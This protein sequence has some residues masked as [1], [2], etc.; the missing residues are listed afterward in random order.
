[1]AQR[2]VEPLLSDLVGISTSV[3][4]TLVLTPSMPL[5]TLGFRSLV[6][7]AP[8]HPAGPGQAYA[9]PDP[10]IEPTLVTTARILETVPTA[11]D[12]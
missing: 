4:P 8:L 11:T 6:S 10:V 1:M 3:P 7:G 2:T 5:E 9:P 12:P